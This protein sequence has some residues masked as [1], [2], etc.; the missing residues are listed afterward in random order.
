MV[1]GF[2]VTWRML[3]RKVNVRAFDVVLLIRILC[4]KLNRLLKCMKWILML[5][6]K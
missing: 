3:N 2:R 5:N 4:L 6:N 1:S